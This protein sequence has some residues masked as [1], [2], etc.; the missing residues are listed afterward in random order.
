M[1]QKFRCIIYITS[2][3]FLSVFESKPND[4]F[5]QNKSL[6]SIDTIYTS[7]NQKQKI[8]EYITK[9]NCSYFLGIVDSNKNILD[10]DVLKDKFE[11][12]NNEEFRLDCEGVIKK[13]INNFGTLNFI[14][15]KENNYFTEDDLFS[16]LKSEKARYTCIFITTKNAPN[17]FKKNIVK[18]NE[19]IV[20]NK[21]D[22]C[23]KILLL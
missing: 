14:Q 9:Y 22:C 4:L 13:I 10:I 3:L 7:N 2:I 15:T 23:V 8:F 17:F 11:N 1:N 20:K 21:V 19:F 12:E 16:M 6:E 5:S 18:W